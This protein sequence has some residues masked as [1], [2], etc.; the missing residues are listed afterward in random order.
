MKTDS[1]LKQDVLEE[2]QW[3]PSIDH[4][5][6]GVSVV[7]GVVTLNG[8]VKSYAEKV[9]AERAVHR[10]VGAEAIAQELHVRLPGEARTADHEIA[11]RVLDMLR[12]SVLMRDHPIEVKVEQGWVTLTGHVEWHYQSEEARRLAA[13]VTG[14]TGVTNKIVVSHRLAASDVRERIRSALERQ[15]DIDAATVTIA[16]EGSRVI[17][18][19]RVRA[20]YE[21]MAAERAAWG[22]AGVSQVVDRIALA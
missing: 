5:D 1:E 20:P 11:R 12:W 22:A 18:G 2:L 15:A 19:G 4:A 13:S 6:I 17:L 8:Y 14:V 9:A 10:V 21:R 3:E 16:V 7:E